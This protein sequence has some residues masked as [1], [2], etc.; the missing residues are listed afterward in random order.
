MQKKLA[1]IHVKYHVVN[2]TARPT[3]PRTYLPAIRWLQEQGYRVVMIG[4][5]QMPAEFA[6]LGGVLNYANSPLRLLS[7]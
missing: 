2:A 6:A 1:L 5:E 3:D 4:R 7:L